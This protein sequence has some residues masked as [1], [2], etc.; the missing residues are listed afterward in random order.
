[1]S[2]KQ[3]RIKIINSLNE[4]LKEIDFLNIID[5]YKFSYNLK[6]KGIYEAKKFIKEFKIKYE[7]LELLLQELIYNEYLSL[8]IN[9]NIYNLKINDFIFSVNEE[10]K[11]RLEDYIE[12]LNFKE[13]LESQ[14]TTKNTEK[15]NKI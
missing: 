11:K 15:R 8:F 14:L 10:S 9:C 6:D 3:E 1:M 5:N 7:N 2:K 13:K 4:E 12:K